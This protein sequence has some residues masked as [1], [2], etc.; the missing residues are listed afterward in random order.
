MPP[1]RLSDTDL[2]R[3]LVDGHP[4]AMLVQ[5]GERRLVAYNRAAGLLLGEELDRGSGAGVACRLL[6]CRRPGGPLEGLCV[7]ELAREAPG[8]ASPGG[9]SVRVGRRV[10]SA[11]VFALGDGA[12]VTV[13]RTEEPPDGAEPQGLRVAQPRLWVRVLGRTRVADVRGS[14]EGRWLGGRTGRLL[15]LLALERGRAVPADELLSRLWPDKA[16]ADRR[17]LR[18]YVH[19][20]RERLEPGGA[21]TPPSSFVVSTLGGYALRAD[22]SWVDADAFERLVTAGLDAAER[23]D[24]QAARDLL[25]RGLE[26]YRGELLADEPYAEWALDERDRL[27]TL[28]ADG[29]RALARLQLAADDPAGAAETL[30]RLAELEPYDVDVHRDLLALLLRRGR[31][32]EAARRFA[33]LRRRMQE[34]FDEPLGFSLSDL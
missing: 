6:G 4:D 28:A 12:T 8:A 31:R 16:S 3:R 1:L 9:L 17:V 5:D 33:R 15:K 26:L 13:L 20:L 25:R 29:L 11:R 14:L 27:H 7:H 21:P 32:S 34:T 10:L 2:A 24:P 23:G 18:Y 22:R 30:A 19:A